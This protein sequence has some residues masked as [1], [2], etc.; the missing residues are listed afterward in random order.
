MTGGLPRRLPSDDIRRA[1]LTTPPEDGNGFDAFAAAL[2]PPGEDHEARPAGLVWD[3]IRI[4][5][6]VGERALGVLHERSGAV[7]E[8][9]RCGLLYWFIR[10]GTADQWGPLGHLRVLGDGVYVVIPRHGITTGPAPHWR[11]PPRM[12]RFLTHPDHL[13]A[14]LRHA[15]RDAFGPHHCAGC[16]RETDEPIPFHR[17]HTE[18]G[19]GLTH[20][21]CLTC[22]R[23]YL[24]PQ[25][26]EALVEEHAAQCPACRPDRPR[27]PLGRVLARVLKGARAHRWAG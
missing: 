25:Q 6:P 26:A 19:P 21:V 3:A 13:H 8:D 10:H 27:C 12:G 16:G 17:E 24:R 11:V 23:E 7:V 9:P 15:I 14:A 1:A 2:P 18:W 22:A 5:T 4:S 20:R